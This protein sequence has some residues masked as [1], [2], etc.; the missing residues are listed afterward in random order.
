M[1]ALYSLRTELEFSTQTQHGINYVVVKDP[2]TNRYLR[3]T[4][5]QGIILELIREPIDLES[6][7]KAA[8]ARFGVP[9]ADRPREIVSKVIDYRRAIN[10]SGIDVYVRPIEEEVEESVTVEE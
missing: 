2:A 10:C 4:E 9:V 8:T 3:F 5:N 1:S 7:A 6:L